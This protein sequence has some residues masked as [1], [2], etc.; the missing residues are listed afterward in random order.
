MNIN[1]LKKVGITFVGIVGAI[2]I[3]FLILPFIISP[4]VNSY[5]PTVNAEIKKATGF[6]SKLEDFRIVTTPKFTIGAKL[7][8]MWQI[9]MLI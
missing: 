8:K 3:L 2:Y 5:L 6:T 9:L 4:I 1:I 7:G